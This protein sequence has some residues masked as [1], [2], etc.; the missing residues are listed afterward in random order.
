[1]KET[2][3]LHKGRKKEE[4][5]VVTEEDEDAENLDTMVAINEEDETEV[6]L[7]EKNKDSF[8]C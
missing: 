7:D 4:L 5:S 2:P 8:L 3:F 6:L 1:M